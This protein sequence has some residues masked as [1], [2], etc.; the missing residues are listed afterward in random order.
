MVQIGRRS[1]L[2][3]LGVG[4]SSVSGCLGSSDAGAES[5]SIDGGSDGSTGSVAEGPPTVERSLP[6]A[7][8]AEELAAASRSGGPPPDGIPAIEDPQFAEAT[9]PPALLDDGDPVFGVVLD[10][11]AKAYPQSVLVWHEIANDVIAGTPVS[12]T[13]CPLTGTAQ[14]FHRGE[15]TFGVSGQLINANLVMFD[16]ATGARWPQML[17]TRITG[18]D[19]GDHLK[20]FRVVWTTWERWRSAHPETVVLTDDTGFARN[21][22][23]DPYGGYNPRSGYYADGSLLFPPLAEDDRLAPKT[24]VIGMRSA[25]G[26][27]AVRKETLREERI[28]EF[29]L[30]AVRHA[31]VYD[32]SL[33]TGYVYRARDGAE[34]D[35]T[36][37]ADLETAT[38][39]WEDGDVVVDGSVHAPDSL[40]FEREIAFDAMWFAWY[41]YYPMTDL[42]R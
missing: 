3:A 31:A 29:D 35:G 8:T 14:G 20:E 21:Y 10:G 37:G 9:D 19:P 11:E 15:T 32:G 16:R 13:Y 39:S 38:L 7:Y 18:D 4:M 36:D 1:L 2:G 23:S 24:V 28:I 34:S 26:A 22:G 27:V 33:D 25:N 6:A 41:G 40:P 17:A 12:V 42:H 30:D 5:G